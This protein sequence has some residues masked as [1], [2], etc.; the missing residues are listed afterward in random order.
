MMNKHACPLQITRLG[1][2]FT[3]SCLLVDFIYT[4]DGSFTTVTPRQSLWRCLCGISP[5]FE[6]SNENDSFMNMLHMNTSLHLIMSS[7]RHSTVCQVWQG[8]G[9]QNAAIIKIYL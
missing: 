4:G 3:Y 7:G 5:S 2:D 6:I 9:L 8:V 1:S